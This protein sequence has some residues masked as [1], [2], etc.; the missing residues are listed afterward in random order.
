MNER[1]FG[2]AEHA[3]SQESMWVLR[4]L[5]WVAA[6]WRPYLGW[7]TL[8]LC[9]LLTM[10]PALL[11]WENRWLRVP[12]LNGRLY[13]AGPLAV[14]LVWLV[15]GW[16]APY[17]SRRK[18]FRIA[19]QGIAI[20]SLSIFVLS[21]LLAGW[22]PGLPALWAAVRGSGWSDIAMQ[23]A[24]AF[25]RVGV[26][27]ALWW[28]GV[29]NNA[30]G[31][32]DL[33]FFGFA[34]GII[35]LLGLATGGLARRTRQGLVAALP[36]LWLVGL[37]MLYS[38]VDRWLIVAGVALALLLHL[39]LDQQALVRRWQALRL[40]Y[41][42][43]ALMERALLTLGVMA[44]VLAVAALTPN[45][46]WTEL[47]GRYYGLIAPLNARL[48]AL[49]KRAFPGMTGVNP[50]ALNGGVAGG[51]P[52][53]F[54]LRA[55]PTASER[56]VMRVRTSETPT[57]YDAPP[58]AHNLR[59]ATFSR[60]DGRGW[61]NPAQLNRTEHAA[62]QPW[63]DLVLTGRR[64]LLQSI[65]LTFA[66]RVIFAA[67]EPVAPSVDYTAEERFPGD[68]VALTADVRSYTVTS[69]VP[70][71]TE[72]ELAALPAWGGEMQLPPEFAL[73]LELPESV[74]ARTRAL[75]TELTVGYTSPY[76][77]AVAIEQY[78]RTFPYDLD[79]PPLPETVT[80]VADYFLFDLQLGYCDYYATAFVVLARA[81]GL[82]A[83]FVTG[84]TSGSWDATGQLWVITE[85][86][87]HSW[88]EVYLPVI[89][90]TPF[91]PT[92]ARPTL[93]RIG[94]ARGVEF[95][96]A[97]PLAAPPM[98]QPP[99]PFDDR[100]LW[101]LAPISLL[102]IGSLVW[103]RRRAFRRE[104]PWLMLLRW[105]RRQGRAPEAGETVLEYG[106]A[107]AAV[108]QTGHQDALEERRIIGRE[109]LQ[110]S[111]EVSALHYAPEAQ[112]AQLRQRIL[113]R[114]QRL[115]GYLRRLGRF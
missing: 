53:D 115:R 29:Q 37:V 47:T 25:V 18:L 31:R 104:D 101:L 24:E 91:E 81:V 36:V 110:M 51:L 43:L 96:P 100:W 78:L 109:V 111:Q 2:W 71:L 60:Y 52:N 97:S 94:L 74:T 48:E 112:R 19:M 44:V 105:G 12:S 34:L 10:L 57:F 30:A 89:G 54:L 1:T 14:V 86:N 45:L 11:L 4:V 95:A 20:I 73:Y 41:N 38:A 67:G 3:E 35:W 103:L 88:P 16:R 21:E 17:S 106:A 66:G 75:A 65:N 8:A 59:S 22:W 85:A 82:P 26:R 5:R 90:W 6:T 72:T 58:L 68:L 23:M 40:D 107:L 15:G 76:S 83:R 69:L 80:D 39:V 93:A 63:A 32:D 99:L 62:E 61:R 42:P 64:P 87:A 9:L 84:F 98:P 46:Y 77:Q 102:V 50:W 108:V 55:G 49:G 92:A 113:E 56:L 28:Q 33:V 27:Y 79:A 70:A 13:V 7:L 114:W